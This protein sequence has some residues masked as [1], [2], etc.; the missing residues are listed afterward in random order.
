MHGNKVESI[1]STIFIFIFMLSTSHQWVASSH[2]LGSGPPVQV[3][4]SLEGKYLHNDNTPYSS[5]LLA[6]IGEQDVI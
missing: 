2:F 1:L 5:F 6:F 3:A 4:I